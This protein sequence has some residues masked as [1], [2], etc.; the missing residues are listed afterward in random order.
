MSDTLSW[1]LGRRASVADRQ[2][3]GEDMV[4]SPEALA[5][6][7]SLSRAASE[8]SDDKQSNG[9]FRSAAL[10]PVRDFPV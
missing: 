9:P 4:P 3:L 6:R 1:L 7:S 5:E 2:A 8:A 10:G